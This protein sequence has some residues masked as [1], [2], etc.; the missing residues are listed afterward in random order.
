MWNLF[1]R[2]GKSDTAALD[3]DLY[4]S[5]FADDPDD[6]MKMKGH[7][8]ISWIYEDRT[9]TI[10]EL[11]SIANDNSIESRIRFLALY[12][13]L[14]FGLTI[15]KKIYFGTIM[16]VP[17]EG[18]YDVLAYYSDL[19]ARYYN[20]SGRAIIYEGGKAFVDNCIEKAN[21]VAIQVCNVLG[22][23]EKERLPRPRG[24]IFRISFLVSDGLYFGNS[25]IKEIGNDQAVST[26]FRNGVEV[27]KALVNETNKSA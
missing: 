21:S 6:F 10:D 11:E 12:T 25:S 3:E 7:K 4:N 26:I 20:Y 13:A 23:W 14:E 27:M 22:P 24:D 8:A 17:V 18:G 5:L 16:E 1:K 19:T 2:K 9:P 15:S